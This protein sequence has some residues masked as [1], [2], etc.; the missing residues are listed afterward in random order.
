MHFLFRIFS[1]YAGF[2]GTVSSHDV[3]T[4]AVQAALA[5]HKERK[6]AV[7]VPSKRRSL[8]VQTSMDAYTP[9]G[10]KLSKLKNQQLFLNLQET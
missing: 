9:P 4:E 2:I 1:A 5:R 10:K 8:V 7:P 6:M 3:H